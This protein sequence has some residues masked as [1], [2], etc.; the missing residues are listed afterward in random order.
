[1][2]WSVLN[3]VHGAHSTVLVNMSVH[4][5]GG[6][7]TQTYVWLLTHADVHALWRHIC[8][9]RAYYMAELKALWWV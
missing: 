7:C 9:T 2:P 3:I 1:M 5:E 8:L 4:K 6:E